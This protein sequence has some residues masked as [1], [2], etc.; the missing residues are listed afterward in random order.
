MAIMIFVVI[1][2]LHFFNEESESNARDRFYK[3]LKISLGFLVPALILVG[4]GALKNYNMDPNTI[5]DKIVTI[6]GVTKFQGSILM[7]LTLIYTMGFVNVSFYTASGLFSWPIG[8]LLG[9]TSIAE[10]CDVVSDQS[11]LY[12]VRIN[13]LREKARIGQ[14]TTRE[15]E[16]LARAEEDLRRLDQE[17]TILTGYSSSWSYKLRYIIRAI[18]II[19]G[20]LLG[21]LSILL[22]ATLIIVNVDRLLHSGGPRQGYILLKLQIFNPLEYVLVKAQDLIFV[23]PLPLLVIT[24]FLVVATISGIRNLGLWF[25]FARLHRVKVGRVPPQA[26]L[27]TC[28]TI[29]LAAAAFNLTLFSLAPQFVTFGDQNYKSTD[30]NGTV[31]VKPCSLGDYHSD[32]ILTR[33]SI[34]LMRI[35]SALWIF[36]T[37]FYWWGWAFVTVATISFLA[38]L[39]RGRRQ[40]G[41]D[42]VPDDDEDFED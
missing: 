6:K 28:I 2:F 22:V 36:G 10:R 25:M 9:T 1:P 40:A 11:D 27:Y 14:L 15:Q 33:S 16:Q 8:L 4:I 7:V 26:L 5:F 38:Y 41:H 20:L 17:E 42:T 18:Q 39:K 19:A 13:N 21:C 37:I 35:M 30:T 24:S 29:M 12:R 34:M 31:V 3:A 32:C 23:G